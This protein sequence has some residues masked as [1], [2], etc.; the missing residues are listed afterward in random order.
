MIT[1]GSFPKDMYGGSGGKSNP[2]AKKYPVGRG[3]SRSCGACRPA[4]KRNRPCNPERPNNP[5]GLGY[6]Y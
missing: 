5:K 6:K 2:K 3:G 1:S 4:N